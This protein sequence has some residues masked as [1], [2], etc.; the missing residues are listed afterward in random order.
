[1]CALMMS[2]S[3]WAS[4]HKTT[5][6]VSSIRYA[7]FGWL[8]VSDLMILYPWQQSL[9]CCHHKAGYL[10]GNRPSSN[11]PACS[12]APAQPSYL[13]MCLRSFVGEPVLVPCI[14]LLI[15]L[16]NQ[17]LQL[18]LLPLQGRVL[19]AAAFV[20]RKQSSDSVQLPDEFNSASLLYASPAPSC[21]PFQPP[22]SVLG[23]K[24]LPQ[25]WKP[26]IQ[27]MLLHWRLLFGSDTKS[28]LVGTAERSDESTR[29]VRQACKSRRECESLLSEAQSQSSS[30]MPC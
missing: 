26:A 17:G 8:M 1:M 13:Q 2:A 3:S 10:H 29:V 24:P 11:S 22:L 28:I 14:H 30:H 4:S 12:R 27:P 25:S 20:W 5:A 16:F 18:S 19:P 21:N 9:V 7:K 23:L 6:I 15:G